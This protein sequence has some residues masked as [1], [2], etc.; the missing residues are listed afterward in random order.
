M[1]PNEVLESIERD[2]P[3]K[4]WPIIGP[5]RGEIL[6]EV[7]ESHRPS[8][9]LEVGTNVG[10]SAIRMGRH[11]KKGQKITCVDISEDLAK[12][13]RSNFAK[14][15]LSDRIEVIVGDA[16]KVLPTLDSNFDLVFLD[17]VKEDYLTYLKTIEHLLHKGSVVIADNVKQFSTTVKPYLDYVRGSGRYSSEYREASSNWG[18]DEP[19]AAEVS[20]RL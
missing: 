6:D 10:Y 4:G 9:I 20:V 7:I 16:L 5:K 17:A 3:Q 19:D 13:A 11:L 18:T 12:V 1:K 8:T 2:A 14:A 15:G